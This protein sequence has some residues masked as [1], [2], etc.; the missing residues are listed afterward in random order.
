MTISLEKRQQAVGISLQK[1]GVRSIPPIRV[2]LALDVSGSAE[3]MFKN[4]MMQ[5]VTDRLLAVASKFD[6]NGEMDMWAFHTACQPLPTATTASYGGYVKPNIL[7]NS[8]ITLWG[9]TS[10]SPVVE[11]A[12]QF[13]FPTAVPTKSGLFGG[14]FGKKAD[15]VAPNTALPALMLILTDGSCND[16][17]A[18]KVALEASLTKNVYWHF[19]G[20]GSAHH[21]KFIEKM[22][23]KYP[24][25]GFVNMGSLAISDEQLYD[26]VIN[27]ELCQWVTKN[28]VAT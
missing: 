6:D 15:V 17:A 26:Q 25:V 3:W 22:A 8:S 20:L 10:Y 5:E 19:V 7:N 21:F 13:F 12:T 2:G 23:D 4:G 11:S 9:G 16:E 24:H 28:G 27:E 1:R 14:L 18:C